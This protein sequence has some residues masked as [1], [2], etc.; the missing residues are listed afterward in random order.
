MERTLDFSFLPSCSLEMPKV[1][2][3]KYIVCL[4]VN[5]LACAEHDCPESLKHC[6]AKDVSTLRYEI[7]RGH[8]G[9]K[10]DEMFKLA[11]GL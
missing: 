2:I 10:V 8:Q 6:N 9:G 1:T 4:I 5:L 3:A 11:L 7:A